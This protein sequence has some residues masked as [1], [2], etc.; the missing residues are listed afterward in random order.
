MADPLGTVAS[1]LQLI[2]TALMAKDGPQEQ[3][4]LLSEI[5]NLRP[6]LCD[7]RSRITASPSSGVL[8]G[9]KLPLEDFK[10]MMEQFTK[11]LRSRDGKSL[12]Y[13]M[14]SEEEHEYM[15][16]FEKFRALLNSWLW[17]NLWCFPL[18]YCEDVEY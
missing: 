15:E 5:N 1:I 13:P 2:D 17:V 18:F 7:L 10:V 9:M 3:Q 4:K 6:L 8:Q 12:T 16:K 14:W 11:K